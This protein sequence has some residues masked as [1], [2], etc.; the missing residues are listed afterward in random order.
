MGLCLALQA[1]EKDTTEAVVRIETTMGDMRVRLYNG[2]PRHRDNFLKLCEEHFYDSLLFH[3]VI[4][5]FMIQAGDPAS[6]HAKPYEVLGEG[7]P[8]YELEAEIN[9]DLYRNLRGALAAAR[10]PDEVNPEYRSS[11]SQFYI[12]VCG[13]RHWDGTYT[14]FG[15]LEEG[16]DVLS[17]IQR[18]ETD[19]FDR[20]LE[21]IRIVRVV[22]EREPLKEAELTSK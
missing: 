10:E 19:D 11:G 18:Q 13:A 3:R 7:G 12:V 8:G 17:D 6:R 21:D 14:V 9:T 20:P 15:C 4:R 1:R 2:T 5:G 22:V 16:W